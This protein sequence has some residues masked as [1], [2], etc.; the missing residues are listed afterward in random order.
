VV[1]GGTVLAGRLAWR[2][3]KA[4]P[5]SGRQT[6]LRATAVVSA[7]AGDTGRV[8]LE[9]AWWNARSP[10]AQLH[11]GQ[12]VRVVD[13]QGLTLIVEPTDKATDITEDPHA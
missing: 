13:L 5:L 1:G 11:D 6:L 9:G 12:T 8:R 10:N 7:A 2:A 3:R 4:P